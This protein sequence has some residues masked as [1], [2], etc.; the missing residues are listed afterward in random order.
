MNGGVS[1]LLS[2]FSRFGLTF[3]FRPSRGPA[4]AIAPFSRIC[5]RCFDIESTPGSYR[6]PD[7]DVYPNAVPRRPRSRSPR[8]RASPAPLSLLRSSR[9]SHRANSAPRATTF[10]G[11]RRRQGG[12]GDDVQDLLADLLLTPARSPL[13]HRAVNPVARSIV[14]AKLRGADLSG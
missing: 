4:A 2:G 5:V 13:P 12:W 6:T 9:S 7:D 11:F 3:W 1:E 8:P 14:T 10:S